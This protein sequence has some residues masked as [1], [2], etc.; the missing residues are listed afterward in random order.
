MNLP[1]HPFFF[2]RSVSLALLL[3]LG[4]GLAGI[5]SPSPLRAQGLGADGEAPPISPAVKQSVDKAVA[6]LLAQQR[7]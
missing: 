3:C 2:R 7:A 1:P 4:V 5:V 6:W